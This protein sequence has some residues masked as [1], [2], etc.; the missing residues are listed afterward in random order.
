MVTFKNLL[1]IVLISVV[2]FSTSEGMGRPLPPSV[3]SNAK[4]YPTKDQVYN[5]AKEIG[6]QHPDI[7]SLQFV[8]ETGNCTSKL[9]KESNN[10]FGFKQHSRLA[11]FST[12]T[13][14]SG[15]AIY[16]NW[17]SSVADY[18]IWQILYCRDLSRERYIQYVK[19][20]YGGGS[21]YNK[22]L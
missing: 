9:C 16:P 14:S 4:S 18:L 15:Y 1:K 19:K 11:S 7:V 3:F 22:L 6:I 21:I 12:G 10:L 13:T 8:I 20:N 2:C 17:K 5:Y